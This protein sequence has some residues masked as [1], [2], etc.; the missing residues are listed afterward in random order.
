VAYCV[1]NQVD[2]VL[3][4]KLLHQDGSMIL[5]RPLTDI[6]TLRHLRVRFAF[7][8]QLENLSLSRCEGIVWIKRAR[9]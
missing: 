4:S 2:L 9:L 7:R 1:P 6:E 5:N 3:Q 8:S